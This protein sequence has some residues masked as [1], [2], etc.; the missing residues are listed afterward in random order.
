MLVQAVH[1]AH[2]A[3][4]AKCL[5]ILVNRGQREARETVANRLVNL[6][7]AWILAGHL[8]A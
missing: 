5:E 2:S 3:D 4:G 7:G 8:Q 6:L 1:V